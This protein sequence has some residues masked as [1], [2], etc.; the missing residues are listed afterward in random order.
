MNSDGRDLKGGNDNA[1][2]G[3]CRHGRRSDRRAGVRHY[4][5]DDE[6]TGVNAD[7]GNGSQGGSPRQRRDKLA[8]S[9]V[10]ECAPKKVKI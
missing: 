2:E 3:F 10:C 9:S 6:D 7:D 5:A 4:D 8:L 1:F